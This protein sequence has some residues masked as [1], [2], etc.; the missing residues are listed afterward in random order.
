MLLKMEIFKEKNITE[1]HKKRYKKKNNKKERKLF[2][3]KNQIN[4][5]RF[6]D[7]LF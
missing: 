4:G 7:Y 6:D 3:E 1:E 5:F 2:L